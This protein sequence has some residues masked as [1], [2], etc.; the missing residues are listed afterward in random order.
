MKFHSSNTLS[1]V[2]RHHKNRLIMITVSLDEKITSHEE[3]YKNLLNA[4]ENLHNS[5]LI[6]DSDYVCYNIG[7]PL[8]GVFLKSDTQKYMPNFDQVFGQYRDLNDRLKERSETFN[9]LQDGKD[10]KIGEIIYEENR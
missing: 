6:Y 3:S 1:E 8:L 2:N 10:I 9:I 4:L 7:S 5:G